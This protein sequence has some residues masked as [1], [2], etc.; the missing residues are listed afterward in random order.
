M[1][2]DATIPDLVAE[3]AL[4]AVHERGWERL[5]FDDIAQHAGVSVDKVQPLAHDA[6]ALVRAAVE[7][8]Y[9]GWRDEVPAWL[10]IP[11]GGSL[12]VGLQ[13]ILRATW[14]QVQ[15]PGVPRLGH[16][17][18][19][20]THAGETDG[21]DDSSPRTV[22]AGFRAYAEDEFTAWFRQAIARDP[23]IGPQA[24]GTDRLCAP[25]VIL[26]FD[27]LLLATRL[28]GHADPDAFRR[29]LVGIVVGALQA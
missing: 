3:A 7:Q 9:E 13:D 25:L 20:Q 14:R 6:P 15:S 22:I 16:L 29:M 27:G 23:S 2:D 11:E 4:L 19:L 21:A 28:D 5:T 17:L 1:T 24:L 18:L 12:S 10:P 8:T 26:A